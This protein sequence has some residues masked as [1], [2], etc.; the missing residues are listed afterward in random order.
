[1]GDRVEHVYR[2]GADEG[3]LFSP[4]IRVADHREFRLCGEVFVSGAIPD[5]E[6]YLAGGD[7]GV[8]LAAC[9]PGHREFFAEGHGGPDDLHDPR[10]AGAAVLVS[11]READ[12]DPAP[13]GALDPADDRSFSCRAVAAGA[14][15]AL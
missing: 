14:R 8:F 1:M 12:R 6:G 9:D 3:V 5:V 2:V 7:V 15:G 13:A 10:E 4:D 11:A